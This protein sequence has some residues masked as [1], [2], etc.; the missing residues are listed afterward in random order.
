VQAERAEA[1]AAKA[2]GEKKLRQRPRGT[3]HRSTPNRPATCVELKSETVLGSSPTC[4][5]EKPTNPKFFIN[6]QAGVEDSCARAA[7]ATPRSIWPRSG[8][9]YDV[10]AIEQLSEVGYQRALQ[11][12]EAIGRGLARAIS[13]CHPIE[14]ASKNITQIP[15]IHRFYL[16]L[17]PPSLG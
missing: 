13:D 4:S 6:Q 17:A 9:L 15:I 7:T 11:V 8:C 14:G 3:A 12:A 10:T 1:E 16:F 2:T 5:S